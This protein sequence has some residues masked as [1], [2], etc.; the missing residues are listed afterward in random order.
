MRATL[1]GNSVIANLTDQEFAQFPASSL[2]CPNFAVQ[3]D[4]VTKSDETKTDLGALDAWNVDPPFV[5][6]TGVE[7]RLTA[8]SGE[9]G[10]E[11]IRSPGSEPAA[12]LVAQRAIVGKHVACV[13]VVHKHAA[14]GAHLV[15]RIEDSKD[16]AQSI[17]GN[18]C[19]GVYKRQDASARYLRAAIASVAR[20]PRAF[21][22]SDDGV[23]VSRTDEKF[24]IGVIRANNHELPFP[25]REIA[26]RERLEATRERFFSLLRRDDNGHLQFSC[27]H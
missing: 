21:G 16:P 19:V 22:Q 4:R 1:P 8:H 18:P 14:D 11:A 24:R 27:F 9:L 23:G 20:A 25:A 26:R 3:N 5:E 10:N 15:V 12:E 17:R 7:E 6:H 2:E 13:I